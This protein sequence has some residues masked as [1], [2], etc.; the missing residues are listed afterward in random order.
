MPSRGGG[1]LWSKA[2]TQIRTRALRANQ[3]PTQDARPDG[4]AI[5]GTCSLRLQHVFAT[6]IEDL[7]GV[8]LLDVI[9]ENT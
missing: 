9:G 4:P 2:E 3:Q 5:E 8:W 7:A 6:S 1:D